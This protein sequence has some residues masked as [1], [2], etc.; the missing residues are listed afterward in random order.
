MTQGR[1]IPNPQQAFGM[2]DRAMARGGIG[3]GTFY[4][5]W[6]LTSEFF[7][8]YNSRLDSFP[9]RLP[10]PFRES[11]YRCPHLLGLLHEH[12]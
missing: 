3:G 6:S 8:A 5:D 7:L 4:Q 1:A 2:I 10:T 9:C 11:G 12:D